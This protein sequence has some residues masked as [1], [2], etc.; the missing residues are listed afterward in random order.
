MIFD[1]AEMG[2]PGNLMSPT[3]F[4]ITTGPCPTWSLRMSLFVHC[5]APD[6]GKDGCDMCILF[7][8]SV[9]IFLDHSAKKIQHPPGFPMCLIKKKIV[10]LDSVD[11][12]Q[13]HCYLLTANQCPNA[14]AWNL[15]SFLFLSRRLSLL[16]P[17]APSSCTEVTHL[18][19]Q[20]CPSSFPIAKSHP[21][22]WKPVQN[23]PV[24]IHLSL[25]I[26]L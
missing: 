12:I 5:A 22:L 10:K 9:H 2:Q 14:I 1:A 3:C 13:N 26:F 20:L 24:E 8:E 16:N 7:S 25:S 18:K 21:S 6:S 11:H 4:V 19:T 17:K 15:E 23:L